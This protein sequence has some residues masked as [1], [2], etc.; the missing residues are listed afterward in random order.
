MNKVLFHVNVYNNKK[1][2]RI[3]VFY[4]VVVTYV[5]VILAILIEF[6][7]GNLLDIDIKNYIVVF[8]AAI[9]MFAVVFPI[10]SNS[11]IVLSDKKIILY[12][13]DNKILLMPNEIDKISYRLSDD[14]KKAVNRLESYR[15]L[16]KTKSGLS[17]EVYFQRYLYHSGG[18][19]L[20]EFQRE[21][22]ER[23]N[24]EMTPEYL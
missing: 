17:E 18:K 16:I 11:K 12:R 23:Y 10:N 6:Y 5:A 15:V 20:E 19:L 22:K 7:S 8:F 4:T 24:L 14:E 9:G 2:K 3:A 1:D 13:G 21:I